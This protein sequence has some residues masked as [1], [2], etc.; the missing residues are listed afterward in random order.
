M[1]L[2]CVTFH[3]IK[4]NGMWIGKGPF[5]SKIKTVLNFMYK[6]AIILKCAWYVDGTQHIATYFDYYFAD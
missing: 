1:L 4:N 5:K 2:H 6:V 3:T